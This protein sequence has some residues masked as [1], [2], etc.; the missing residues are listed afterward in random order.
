LKQEG[1][2]ALF[3]CSSQNID[4]LVTFF[5]ASLRA[6]RLFVI[7]VYTANVLRELQKLSSKLPCPSREYPNIRVFF[8]P[9]LTGRIVKTGGKEAAYHFVSYKITREEIAARQSE[10]LMLV[11]PSEQNSFLGKIDGLKNGAFIY[12]LWSG[13]RGGETQAAFEN[14]LAERGFPC[15][16]MHTS[17]HADA[18]A[19]RGLVAALDPKKI[20]P[21]HTFHPEAFGGFSDKVSVARDG[22]AVIIA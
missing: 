22:E 13:Y 3:Q 8:P 11:R 6:N 9:S 12:S 4:R 14:F 7:D 15:T 1:G 16:E 19:I 20:V 17:G 10:I 5:R 21:V 18:Q 2:A